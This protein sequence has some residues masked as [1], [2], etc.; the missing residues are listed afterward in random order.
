M[1]LIKKERIRWLGYALI[2]LQSILLMIMAFWLL[3]NKYEHNAD[4]YLSNQNTYTFYINN[5]SDKHAN[6]LV[7]YLEDETISHH[8][9]VLR[10]DHILTDNQ[11]ESLNMGVM[12]DLSHKH[13]DFNFLGTSILSRNSLQDLLTSNNP[14]ATLGLGR[15]SANQLHSIYTPP[16]STK[17]VFY[18]LGTLMKNSKTI[19]GKY[20]VL[21]IHNDRQFKALLQRIA[22]IIK[23]PTK[24]LLTSQ[25]GLRY[26]NTFIMLCVTAF[27]IV[28]IILLV[29]T[30]IILFVRLMKNIGILVLI[31]WSKATIFLKIA[32]P[33]MVFSL[34]AAL[35]S[36]IGLPNLFL[37]PMRP[38]FTLMSYFIGIEVLNVFLTMLT[39]ICASAVLFLVKNID[40]IKNIISKK[41]IYGFILVSYLLLSLSVVI[42]GNITDR[43]MQSIAAN[44]KIVQQWSSV[45]NIKI[46]GN[47]V[48]TGNMQADVLGHQMYK[49][50][51][52]NH[53]QSG[54]YII[55][56]SYQSKKWINDMRQEGT[57]HHLPLHPFWKMTFSPN[58]AQKLGVRISASNLKAANSGE[59]LFLIPDS[60]SAKEKAY[61]MAFLKEDTNEGVSENDINTIFKQ[62]R[63]FRFVNYHDNRSIFTWNQNPHSTHEFV[64]HPIISIITPAN[65]TYVEIDG[66]YASGLDGYLKFNNQATIKRSL[67]TK[68]LKQYGLQNNGLKF[69]S[70]NEYINGLQKDLMLSIELFGLIYC[71]MLLM[72]TMLVLLLINF[73]NIVN[74]EKIKVK[75]YLG[76]SFISIYQFPLLTIVGTTIVQLLIAV[77]LSTR[78][79]F[80]LI[81]ISFLIQMVAF[82]KYKI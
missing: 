72:L 32:T 29:F 49:W 74:G 40:L 7:N 43:P 56:S 18:Q 19:N 38:S 20:E 55:N 9:L 70:V 51:Q 53:N 71:V 65:M 58:Y 37:G 62:K 54:V 69:N 10:K 14:N 57:Y 82:M 28:D 79:N 8:L 23:Q 11:N 30:F 15:G 61:L 47:A 1:H 77:V 48:N 16:F 2:L 22:T 31:G 35:I 39:L 13:V 81:P 68:V 45:R 63:Q 64:K 73:F 67:N 60:L 26:D 41:I 27:I 12:G 33:F 44:N 66:L 25:N 50:Y 76:F 52:H 21:G 5:S 3:G 36:G 78:I 34:G 46:L 17:L 75:K 4:T 59:R 24:N 6:Q 80:L 42:V